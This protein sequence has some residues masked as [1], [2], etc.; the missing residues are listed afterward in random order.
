VRQQQS[1]KAVGQYVETSNWGEMEKLYFLIR[2]G[3]V[4]LGRFWLL[5]ELTVS[6]TMSEI[7]IY[8]MS[9]FLNSSAQNYTSIYF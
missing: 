9:N 1:T 8:M 7:L 6:H 5:T 4:F 3:V 2:A